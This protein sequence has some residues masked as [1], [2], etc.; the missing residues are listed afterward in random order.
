MDRSTPNDFA[1]RHS[2]SEL[3]SLNHQIDYDY[4]APFTNS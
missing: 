1:I 4:D 3:I 2:L